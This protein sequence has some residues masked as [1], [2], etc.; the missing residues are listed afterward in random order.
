MLQMYKTA[1][2]TQ[3][4]LELHTPFP[5]KWKTM[6]DLENM[7][8]EWMQQWLLKRKDIAKKQGLFAQYADYFD[9]MVRTDLP[10]HTDNP[11]VS[12]ERK[13]RIVRSLHRTNIL[14]GLYR[15]Y[16]DILTPMIMKI[17]SAR[18]RKV[19]LL[20]LA[21]GSGEMAMSLARLAKNNNLPVE[22]TGSDYVESVVKDAEERAIKRGLDMHFRTINALDMSG[23]KR[24]EYDILLVIGTMHHFT[25]GQ[26]SVIIAQSKENTGSVF[27]G[28]DGYRSVFNLL[29]LPFVH[30]ITFLPDHIHDAWFTARKFYTLFE[31]EHIAQVAVPDAK[32]SVRH[33]FPGMSVLNVH[34]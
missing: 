21:S 6:I 5:P 13:L 10:E 28:I 14:L 11:D 12:S 23:I 1:H 19:R 4:E 2:L 9:K 3:S 22:V 17:A 25:P 24:G 7:T 8:D 34:F 18:N 31:L 30:L 20:E 16:I 15:R 29:G 33:S 27:V 32:V 26:L